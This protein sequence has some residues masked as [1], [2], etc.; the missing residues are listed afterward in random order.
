MPDPLHPL[1]SRF[2]AL[3]EPPRLEILILL[4]HHGEM[5]VCDVEAVLGASQSRASRHLSLLARAGFLE[6]RR[7]GMWVH[8][9]I[10]PDPA[11]PVARLLSVVRETFPAEHLATLTDR[12]A[13][14][15]AAKTQRPSCV[16]PDPS[17][18]PVPPPPDG[19]TP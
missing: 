16:V 8:Y 2:K 13:A 14:V 19:A 17:P 5:C 12:L 6:G 18:N 9:R 7:A 10:V 3:S 11:A 15:R 1:S 4:L